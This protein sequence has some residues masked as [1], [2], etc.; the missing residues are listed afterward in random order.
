MTPERTPEGKAV[1][2]EASTGRRFERWPVDARDLLA[3]G[4]YTTDPPHPA[5]SADTV[6][7][8]PGDDAP[9]ATGAPE[10]SDEP[11]RSRR[12]RA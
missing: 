5:D 4:G 2:Y 6:S 3:T 10:S 9:A 1:L 12:R 8:V 7:V 11:P